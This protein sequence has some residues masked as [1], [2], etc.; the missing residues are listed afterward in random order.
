MVGRT[1]SVLL[2]AGVIAACTAAMPVVTE[3]DVERARAESPE[4]TMASLERGRTLYLARC[5][6]CHEAYHP[7]TR[8]VVEW[9]EALVEMSDR[10]RLKLGDRA[11]VRDYLRVFATP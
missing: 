7:A 1:L 4:V 9:D 8:T 3:A 5:A 6:S 2:V 11:L 10:A